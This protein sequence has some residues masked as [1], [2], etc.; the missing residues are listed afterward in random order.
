MCAELPK[1]APMSK[2][3]SNSTRRQLLLALAASAVAGPLPLSNAQAQASDRPLRILVGFPPGG[4]A[5]TIA[6]LLA[7]RLPTQL[8]GQAVVVDNKP[9]AAG[10]IAIDQLK[11]SP[12]DGNTVIIMP[13]GPVVLFPHVYKKLSYDPV[14]DLA[15]ISRLA[16]FQFCVVSGP[17]S[18]VK[19]VAE[20]VARAKA[21]PSTASF[22]S[23]GNGTVPHFLGLMIGD[24]AG[25]ELQH[26]PYQGGAPAMNALMG[27]H[28]G[29]TM[30]VVVEALEQ[31]RA[32]K[33]RVIAVS[34]AQRSPQLPE[35]PTLREQGVPMDATAWFAMYGPGGLSAELTNKLSQAVQAAMKD[36][37][38]SARLTSLGLGPIAS[39]PAQL[40]AVQ[41]ADFEKWAKPV[42]ASGFQ[43]D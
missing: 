32:G 34:G 24:A 1:Q 17:K 3:R 12:P 40:A 7:E 23:S 4:S 43:A 39:T 37:A 31:H 18:N 21:D 19:T 33:V 10:R 16:D 13:S 28:V 6:R 20:M 2:P 42:K 41:K 5:D 8:G 30:D 11:N 35:V 14:K 9:G 27:G 22:G 15:P 25:V 38:F 36:P 29:Y 26:V